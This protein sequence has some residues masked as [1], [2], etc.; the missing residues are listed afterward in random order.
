MQAIAPGSSGSVELM[1]SLASAILKPVRTLK[2]AE[3]ATYFPAVSCFQ[4]AF[5][6]FFLWRFPTSEA[7]SVST[8]FTLDL[9]S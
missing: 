7:F 4:T 1:S 5:A 3:S 8:H 9:I 6:A 2:A